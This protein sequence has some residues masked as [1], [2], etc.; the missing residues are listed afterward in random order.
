M[1]E[2]P[3]TP[4][5]QSPVTPAPEAAA[6]TNPPATPPTSVVGDAGAWKEYVNDDTKSVE[7]NAA[8]KTA[9]DATKPAAAPAATPVA[10]LDFAKDIKLPDGFEVDE[11]AAKEFSEIINDSALTPAARAQKLIDL[12]AK[13]FTSIAEARN[14]AWDDLQKDWA[15]KVQSDPVIGGEKLATVSAGIGRL[16]DTIGASISPTAARE[17]REVMNLTGAGNHP[18]VVHFMNVFAT[19][20]NEGGPI[21]PPAPPP[22]QKSAAEVLFPSMAKK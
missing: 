15:G 6:I 7:E 18:A 16:I 9:H 12:Q 10:P 20:L 11:G 3:L 13:T 8:A 22:E 5:P 2:Q 21:T 1:S 14:T 19:K 4:T 17:F